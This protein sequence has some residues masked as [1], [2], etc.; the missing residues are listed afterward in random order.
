MRLSRINYMRLHFQWLN[1][2]YQSIN[3]PRHSGVQSSWFWVLIDHVCGGWVQFSLSQMRADLQILHIGRSHLQCTS[4]HREKWVLNHFAFS[5]SSLHHACVLY[6]FMKKTGKF[7][8][9]NFSLI[10][11]V[12][13]HCLTPFNAEMLNLEPSK[14]TIT[15]VSHPWSHA[16]KTQLIWG[17]T[18]GWY[19]NHKWLWNFQQE[20]AR[21]KIVLESIH[22]YLKSRF[23]YEQEEELHYKH[24]NLPRRRSKDDLP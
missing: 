18:L 2:E 14:W 8:V 19:W 12:S 4:T 21:E 1:G 17:Y 15:M 3:L 16:T 20:R 11:L 7:H 13:S 23:K 5:L 22:S 24:S 10:F 9:G 6:N